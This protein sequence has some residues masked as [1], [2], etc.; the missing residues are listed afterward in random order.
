MW[1]VSSAVSI[2]TLCSAQLSCNISYILSGT[3]T[4]NFGIRAFLW[5]A[6]ILLFLEQI[7]P[8]WRHTSTR[9]H[10]HVASSR[11]D[12]VTL[13]DQ[14]VR[15]ARLSCGFFIVTARNQ[16]QLRRTRRLYVVLCSDLKEKVS[17]SGSKTRFQFRW[18]CEWMIRSVRAFGLV[19]YR[20]VASKVRKEYGTLSPVW[21]FIAYS[22]LGAPLY[23]TILSNKIVNSVAAICA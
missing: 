23:P 8:F 4:L 11:L 6:I 17:F 7:A 18:F 21:W 13:R 2:A 22:V 5:C 10:A 14:M 15:V 20:A 3:N 16:T 19:L 1:A 9:I 12:V